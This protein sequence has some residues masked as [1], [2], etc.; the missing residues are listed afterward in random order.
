MPRNVYSYDE[1]Q[2]QGQ[3]IITFRFDADYIST[4]NPAHGMGTY[5]ILV[6]K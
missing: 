3:V 2:N 5:P 6:D 4:D 1:L